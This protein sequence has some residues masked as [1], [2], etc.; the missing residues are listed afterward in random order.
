MAK[1]IYNGPQ[2][3]FCNP[4][5]FNG[6]MNMMGAETIIREISRGTYV[7][8]FQD[9]A[10]KTE[11]RSYPDNYMTVVLFGDDEKIGEVE[12]RILEEI[13]RHKKNNKD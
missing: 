12:K 4:L 9:I 3:N 8:F 10:I 6:M 11:A 2:E 7:H 5:V 1:E 13:K